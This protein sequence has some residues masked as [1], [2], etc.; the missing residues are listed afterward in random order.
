MVILSPFLSN[1]RTPTD[2]AG[3]SSS[4]GIGRTQVTMGSA[5]SIAVPDV[6][7]FSELLHL[8]PLLTQGSA[9]CTVNTD[10]LRSY[11]LT[12]KKLSYIAYNIY[13]L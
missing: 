3:S 2:P 4:T 11:F 10:E 6:I 7:S 9:D 1:S 13:H 12:R 5:A 8:V